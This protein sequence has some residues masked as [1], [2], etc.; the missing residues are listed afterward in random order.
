MASLKK[1]IIANYIG[2]AWPALL[3]ILLVP[4]YIKFLGIEAYGLV[5]FFTTLS[6]VMGIF[7]LGIGSTMNRELAKRSAKPAEQS[8][9][10]DLVKTLEIIYWIIAVSVGIVV[11]C[12]S[13]FIANSWVKAETLDSETIVRAVQ[14]MGLSIAL[15]F[16]MSLYQGGL[17]GLQKQVLVNKI[18][19][20]LGTV[21][22]LGAVL[23]LWGIS[24]TIYAFFAWQAVI[25]IIGSISFLLAIWSVLPKSKIKARFSIQILSDVWRYAAAVSANALIGMCMSQLDKVILSTMLSL[26]MFA[27]YSIAATVASAIWMIILPYNTAIFPKLVELITKDDKAKLK[28]FFH[29]MSQILSVILLPIGFVLIF[30]SKEIL[31]LWLKDEEVA[32][33]SYLIMSFLVF[34]TLLN[35]LVS[36]P[37]NS[38]NA[39]GWPML[40]TYTNLGQAIVVVPL[41]IYLVNEYDGLGASISWVIMNSTYILI[42]VPIFFNSYLKEEKKKWYFNDILIPM[43]VSSFV[44]LSS[45]LVA[46]ELDSSF[47][48]LIWV[49]ITGSITILLTGM[50]MSAIRGLIISKFNFF[51]TK[52]C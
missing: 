46:P 30:F 22:G 13:S 44:C 7:D 2:R 21:R 34:G 4:V 41:I 45:R 42:S 37:I 3:S 8:S 28:V 52:K 51:N 31:F 47:L 11:I 50:S 35:G 17:M 27:Y 18:L 1:N 25:S 32:E 24:S 38:A 39:F 12:I 49:L 36:V 10:R 33:N 20:I 5:G 15:R 26:K 14:F 6:A 40:T 23:V 29:R 19:I 48:I 43:A 9:Q 16:P